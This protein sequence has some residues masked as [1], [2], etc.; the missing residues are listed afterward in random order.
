MI[1][2]TFA[3]ADA[4]CLGF[5]AQNPNGLA[6][7]H[8]DTEQCPFDHWQG[9]GRAIRRAKASTA[10]AWLLS[11]CL[12]GF[13]AADVRAAIRILTAQASKKF[14][15]I[16]SVFIDG[17]ADAVPDVN[18][19]EETS[20]LITELHKLAIEFDCPILNIIHVNPGSD[21]KTRGHLGR[22]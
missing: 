1:A 13:S 3:E 18:D 22:S 11:Y 21:F 6:V 9:I 19:P 20:S 8:L 5:T 10:P 4:D 7:V 17:I 12:T 15:G 16:H 14:G 2:S